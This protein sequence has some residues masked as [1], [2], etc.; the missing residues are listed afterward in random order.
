MVNDAGLRV[1]RDSQGWGPVIVETWVDV[2]RSPDGERELA[3]G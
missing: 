1:E 3:V 2:V